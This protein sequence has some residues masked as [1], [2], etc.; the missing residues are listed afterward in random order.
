MNAPVT[1][2]PASR[3]IVFLDID[4]TIVG[5]IQ[6]A[7]CE[8]ELLRLF[9]PKKIPAFKRQLV[10]HLRY[11]LLR[12]H[13]DVFLRHAKAHG[14]ELYI[15]T[16][17]DDAWARMLVPCIEKCVGVKFNRPI[18]S[19]S[20]C[21][22]TAAGGF[23]KCLDKAIKA[24]CRRK[25]HAA[26]A[27]LIDNNPDVLHS[28]AKSTPNNRLVVCPTYDYM[29]SYDVL[30]NLDIDKLHDKFHKIASVLNKYGMLEVQTHLNF[31]QFQ[32][33]YFR[34]LTKQLARTY[35]TNQAALRHDRFWSKM[36]ER[37]TSLAHA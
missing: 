26:G 5:Q 33:A 4:G 24:V 1:T 8:Y 34:A 27:V 9:D 32:H 35:R 28:S 37:R 18:F 3:Q 29:Y 11:G 20:S 6:S 13:F 19:R 15:Y 2:P 16:A 21:I 14:L 36:A 25:P 31:Q 23:S 7:V 22:P 30:A 12:P 17:S 10:A